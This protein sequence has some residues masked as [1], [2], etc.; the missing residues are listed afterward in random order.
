MNSQA[1]GKLLVNVL[2]Q[3]RKVTNHPLLMRK[4]Y[5]ETKL[6]MMAHEILKEEEFLD[7]DFS[8]VLEDMQ[9]MS[10]FE[11][12]NLCR[13]FRRVKQFRLEDNA[14]MD[15]GKIEHLISILR[16]CV[17]RSDRILLFSQFVIVLDILERVLAELGISFLRLDGSTAQAERQDLIDEFQ[18]DKSVKVFLL[19]TKAGGFGINLTGANVVVLYDIDFNPHNDAQAEDRAH[20]VGQTKVVDV[21]RLVTKD[22][23]E[24]HIYNAALRKLDLDASVSLGKES[25]DTDVAGLLDL[26]E[27]DMMKT[28]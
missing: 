23:V 2:M 11:L 22:T 13:K 15:A 14:V 17:E 6:R 21:I 5:T 7:S 18:N 19:S 27:Q 8:C 9:Q 20:R 16:D 3:L 10:D 24:E 28:V 12:D 1:K 4:K 26:I 25:E